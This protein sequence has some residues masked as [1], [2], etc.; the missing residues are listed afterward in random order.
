MFESAMSETDLL[1]SQGRLESLA[2]E[3]VEG[4]SRTVHYTTR[5]FGPSTTKKIYGV[6][7][8]PVIHN[9]T[10]LALLIL[11][12]AHAGPELTLH[13][14]SRSDLIRKRENVRLYLQA[15]Q[16]CNT[17]SE[18]LSSLFPGEIHQ[19]PTAAEDGSAS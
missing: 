10:R 15:L 17:S 5:R 14:R 16:S 18:V 13:R 6:E 2:I 4:I 1:I 12:E 8:L 7:R 9:S 11:R 3:T 19:E